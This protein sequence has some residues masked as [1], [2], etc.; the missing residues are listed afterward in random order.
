MKDWNV[1]N[2]NNF[3]RMFNDCSI[4]SDISPLQNWNLSKG[5][6][7]ES[8][9]SEC[10][11]LKNLKPIENWDISNGKNFY[12]MFWIKSTIKIDKN[13]LKKWNIP[14]DKLETMFYNELN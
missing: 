10:T 1:S 12:K 9:F 4:L 11:S 3:R 7:F 14:E 2:G 5:I 6:N 8:M 13:L